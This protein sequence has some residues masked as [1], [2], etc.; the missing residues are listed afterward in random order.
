MKS[1]ITS[2]FKD[3][4]AKPPSQTPGGAI[5][6]PSDSNLP[7]VIG[8]EGGTNDAGFDFLYAKKR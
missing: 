6:V 5:T 1:K 2:K 8:Y 3:A 7:L 4:V